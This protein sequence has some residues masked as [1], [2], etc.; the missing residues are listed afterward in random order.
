LPPPVYVASPLGFTEPMRHFYEAV[1]LPNVVAAGLDPLDPWVGGAS[2][3]AALQVEEPAERRRA[4]ATANREVGA[5]NVELIDRAAGVLAVLD[6]TDVD[7]G[8]AAEI[9]WAAARP[10]PIVGWRS[11]LRRSGDNEATVVNLQVEHFIER[12][13]GTIETDLHAAVDA[14]RRLLGA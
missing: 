14:L 5:A 13:G 1:L 4:L 3:A 7:S 12:T 10:I 2:I 11:D 6:G 9:G 8:T